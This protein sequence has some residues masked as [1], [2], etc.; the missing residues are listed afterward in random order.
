MSPCFITETLNSVSYAYLNTRNTRKQKND[1]YVHMQHNNEFIHKIVHTHTI[2]N[3]Q[4]IRNILQ[5]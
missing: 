5:L 3:I 2:N 1:I 4:F